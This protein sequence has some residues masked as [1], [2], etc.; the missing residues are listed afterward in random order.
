MI[1]PHTEIRHIN[2]NIGYGVFATNRI[3][4]GTI[5][6]VK[7]DLE[8]EISNEEF[9]KYSPGIRDHLEKYSYVDE[10]GIRILSWDFAKYVNHCCNANNISTAYGFDIAVRDIEQGEELTCDYGVLNVD[11]EMPLV[12]SKKDCRGVLKPSDFE[13]YYLKWDEL[14]KSALLEFKKVNQPLIS[15]VTQ[16][17]LD[18]LEKYFNNSEEYQSVIKLKY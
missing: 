7:D 11:E 10:R 18:H 2:D 4:K 12:C 3:P 16:R 8:V 13:T 17:K 9:Q 1:H 6:Y 5:V 14:L 15:L